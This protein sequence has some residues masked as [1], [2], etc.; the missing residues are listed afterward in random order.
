MDIFTFHFLYK[1]YN[2]HFFVHNSDNIFL[3]EFA[4]F[5]YYIFT[6]FFLIEIKLKN[7][8]TYLTKIY[9]VSFI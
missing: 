3:H 7:Q 5:F 2:I 8:N 1:L 9:L 6:G 4:C